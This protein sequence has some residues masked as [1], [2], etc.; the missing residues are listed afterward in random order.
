[1]ELKYWD[2]HRLISPVNWSLEPDPIHFFSTEIG[3][4][5]APQDMTLT[6]TGGDPIEVTGLSIGGTDAAEFGFT[7]DLPIV[8]APG[9]SATVPVTFS[10]TSV[11]SKGAYMEATHS[12][13]NATQQLP[14]TGEAIPNGASVNVFNRVN[15]GG[16]TAASASGY[17]IDWAEDQADNGA[18]AGGDAGTGNVNS[19]LISG[20]ENTFGISDAISTDDAIAPSAGP[21]VFQT[22]RYDPVGGVTT[23]CMNFRL[24]PAP[25]FKSVCSLPKQYLTPMEQEYLMCQ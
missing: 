25:S 7:A 21:G 18:N 22:M 8:L 15:G 17:G 23:W 4:T 1:M 3:T 20:G 16:P 2:H 24:C 12:G 14:L 13:V 10:P 9:T 5:S 19:A 6:N 11:G